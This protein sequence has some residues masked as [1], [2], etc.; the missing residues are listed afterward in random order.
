MVAVLSG[1]E[2][3]PQDAQSWAIALAKAKAAYD[4]ATAQIYDDMQKAL[5]DEQLELA[6]GKSL[7]L[8]SAK[9]NQIEAERKALE[10]QGQ[11]PSSIRAID[12]RQRST[13]ARKALTQVYE[14]AQRAAM[15]RHDLDEMNALANELGGFKRVTDYAAWQT[16]TPLVKGDW[17]PEGKALLSPPTN[18]AAPSPSAL[19]VMV[20]A[21]DDV[22]QYEIEFVVRLDGDGRGFSVRALDSEL[23]PFEHHVS[24][25]EVDAALAASRFDRSGARFLIVAQEGTTE[26]ESYVR[27]E[28][29]GLRLSQRPGTLKG[30]KPRAQAA[31]EP[32]FELKPD[33][34]TRMR[35]ETLRWKPLMSAQ[36]L[37]PS[38]SQ[39]EVAVAV[40]PSNAK[41]TTPA[42]LTRLESARKAY[43]AEI[44][45]RINS[46]MDSLE[47][48]EKSLIG[49]DDTRTQQQLERILQAK[50]D[51]QKRREL[52]LD[53]LMP[54]KD[55]A[56]IDAA[57][58][59]LRQVYERSLKDLRSSRDD[60]YAEL[61]AE[62]GDEYVAF[63]LDPVGLHERMAAMEA[64]RMGGGNGHWE[65][66]DDALVWRGVAGSAN[67][68]Y[69][70]DP[71]WADYDVRCHITVGPDAA[72]YYSVL[73]HVEGNSFWGL[74]CGSFDKANARD[75]CSW[76]KGR[77]GS[78]R[79]WRP[80]GWATKPGDQFVLELQL[81][82]EQITALCN[83]QVLGATSDDNLVKGQVG[84]NSEGGAKFSEIEVRLPDGRPLWKGLPEV[85]P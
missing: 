1:A 6:H 80:D 59:A 82:G 38:K 17:L 81:R 42:A 8:D 28:V 43:D 74:T 30:A 3:Q 35:L 53:E 7:A 68:I 51:L 69:F 60:E 78:A 23:Q 65:I 15:Q 14:D 61:I 27:I 4:V 67:D 47:R 83:G 21:A 56:G 39:D 52:P 66:E 48:N 72:A 2:A 18:D 84:F 22:S 36:G 58:A 73:A 71:L 24:R 10:T 26:Q 85:K 16:L 34:G 55:Q 62:L 45:K 12:L 41:G 40:P 32:W 20:D 70:G 5:R 19:T 46:V 76:I 37:A 31:N 54:E 49:K 9:V 77:R 11:W 33:E 75:L 63:E 64:P 44:S 25:A 50:S 57:R 29:E 79:V 13:D